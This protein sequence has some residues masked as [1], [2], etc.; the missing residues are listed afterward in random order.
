MPVTK[1]KG[2]TVL[3]YIPSDYCPENSKNWF[4]IPEGLD[5]GKKLFFY[6]Y[7]HGT[8]NP[9][10]TIVF[11]HG[12]PESSY[13]YRKVIKSLELRDSG[14]FRI[15]A[16]DHIGFG[17]SDQATYEMVDMHHA[18]NLLQLV[19]YLDLQNV[20]LVVHDW[21]GPIGIGAFIREPERVSHLIVLNTTIFPIPPDGMLYTNYPIKFL[22]WSGFPHLVP[23]FLW[24]VHAAF[25]INTPPRNAL[26]LMLHYGLYAIRTALNVLPE[27]DKDAQIVFR[28]Q[29]ASA[30]NARSSKRQVLQTPVWGHGYVYNEPTLGKQDNRIFYKY[31]QDHIS[32]LW[33]PEGRKIGVRAILGSWDPLA[34]NSVVEQW[35]TALP[36]LVGNVK[37]YH[38]TSHFV[39]ETKGEEIADAIIDVAF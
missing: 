11:V 25:S 10:A 4:I 30:I 33:G 28:K 36:Q 7:S 38:D 1:I 8:A 13:T 26:S 27:K 23:N 12:N 6:D 20:T 2:N 35:T 18:T 31:M 19:R 37:T 5:A 29:F 15:I 9:S 17:L 14:C 3:D 22:P 16:M 39:E 24:G 32:E 21:G 34:K